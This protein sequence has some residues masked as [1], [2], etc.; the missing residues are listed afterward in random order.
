LRKLARQLPVWPAFAEGVNGFGDLRLALIIGETGDLSAYA[1]HCRVWKRMGLAVIGGERQRRVTD[2]EKAIAFGYN[3][4]RRSIIWNLGA[5]LLKQQVRAI[6]DDAG[7]RTGTSTPIG[8]YGRIYLERKAYEAERVE[9]PA[10]AHNRAS[11]YMTKALLR[12]LW[13][14][15]RQT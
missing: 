14:A 3:A 15:W 6:K 11:R 7:K 4:E 5:E 2:A 9:T 8:D 10:H 1:T 12:D 13:Q